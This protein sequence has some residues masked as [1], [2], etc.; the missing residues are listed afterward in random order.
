LPA[1]VRAAACCVAWLLPLG[2]IAFFVPQFEDLFSSLRA[3]AELPAL[4]EWLLRIA[5]LDKALFFVPSLLVFVLLV[6]ADI[7]MAGFLQR[8]T[9]KWLYWIWFG[10]VV[11]MGIVFAAIVTIALLLPMLKMSGSV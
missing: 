4:T 2:L 5:S 6:F 8:S 3:R 11:V 1:Y 7:G 9:Q 10:S